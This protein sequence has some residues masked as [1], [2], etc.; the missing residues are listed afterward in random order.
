MF[1]HEPSSFSF[2]VDRKAEKTGNETTT[3]TVLSRAPSYFPSLAISALRVER[4]LDLFPKS[5]QLL[6]RQ[7][8]K[9]CR[10]E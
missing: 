8:F 9:F 10:D 2:H 3:Q 5:S 7:G 1:T 6:Q 4:A